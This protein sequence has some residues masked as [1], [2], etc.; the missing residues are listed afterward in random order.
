MLTE[1]AKDPESMINLKP[2]IINRTWLEQ[3]SDPGADRL[4]NATRKSMRN[5]RLVYFGLKVLALGERGGEDKGVGGNNLL[6]SM[7]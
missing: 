4:V 5:K 7:S 2:C 1:C 6:K 3:C